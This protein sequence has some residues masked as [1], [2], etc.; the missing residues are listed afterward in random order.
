MPILQ[1]DVLDACTTRL[2]SKGVRSH[3]LFSAISVFFLST[4]ALVLCEFESSAE[5]LESPC[6]TSCTFS[7][8]VEDDFEDPGQ[9]RQQWSSNMAQKCAGQ[10]RES[11][12]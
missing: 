4:P 5:S 8:Q 10:Q 12:T 3:Q 9:W 2:L 11:E 1:G 6:L 7:V